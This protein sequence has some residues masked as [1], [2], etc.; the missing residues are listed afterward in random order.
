RRPDKQAL[1]RVEIR[2]LISDRGEKPFA[3]ALHELRMLMLV[4]GQQRA[5]HPLHDIRARLENVSVDLQTNVLPRE[6]QFVQQLGIAF[7]R[8]NRRLARLDTQLASDLRRRAMG[9]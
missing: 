5:S 3:I 1:V 2:T 8:Q 4:E 7:R 9:M 6:A